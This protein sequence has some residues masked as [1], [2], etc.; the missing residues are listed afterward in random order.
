MC[1][2][3]CQA[4]GGVVGMWQYYGNSEKRRVG[5]V[6]EHSMAQGTEG[7]VFCVIIH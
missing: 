6:K 4:P 3:I 2:S 1:D 7:L 5:I